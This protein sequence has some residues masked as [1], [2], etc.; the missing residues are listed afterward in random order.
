MKRLLLG[1]LPFFFYLPAQALIL[2][3]TY[4]SGREVCE[5]SS[6]QRTEEIPFWITV[7]VNY[8]DASQGTT[9]IYAWI[10][11][12]LDPEKETMIFINGGPGDTA[13]SLR[14]DLDHWNVIFFD[15]RGNSCSKPTTHELYL[16]RSF[17]SS[18]NT[19]RDI[20]EIRRFFE[21][22]Q[23]SVYGVSYGTIP[24]HLYGHFFP[25]NTK[26]VVLEGT[27]FQSDESLIEP[28]RRRQKLQTFF[29]S[30]PR[31]KQNRILS[32]S[33]RPEFP[34][35][36]FS[37]IGMMML[38]MDN[39]QE[40]YS[41]FLDTIIWDETAA[42]SMLG[43]FKSAEGED[44]EFGFGDVMMGMIG[45]QELNMN[46]SE[47]SF[48]S[49]FEN[50]KL[51]A[52]KTNTLKKLYCQSLGFTEAD[53]NK[54]FKASNYPT[55]VPVT[56]FQGSYDGATVSTQ[57][58]QHFQEAAK[59]FAQL[60]IST[61]G[62]QLPLH[63]KAASYAGNQKTVSL[64]KQ[65]LEKALSGAPIPPAQI[66]NLNTLPDTSWAQI[67]QPTPA[68]QT[69]AV[70]EAPIPPEQESVVPATPPQA[71][72]ATITEQPHEAPTQESPAS[73]ALASTPLE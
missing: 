32:L 10:K 29:E 44:T 68:T 33:K 25:Q 50:G 8:A 56:Y 60:L 12:P 35:N 26:G 52:D 51:V 7:P 43:A 61:T 57:S 53:Q 41:N 59:G 49:V 31:E 47:I 3:E 72:P 67:L 62:G 36:W 38:S 15:Q 16:S 27:I 9:Q 4:Y 5:R 46:N 37:T 39:A 18:E 40:T 11:K 48:Y 6:I 17:Y 45:C 70:P 65:L 42:T 1:L 55:V 22:R 58:V 14:L 63:S 66:E 64:H 2:S 30:L 24:A 20:N 19:A 73:S 28:E 71:S 13:H 23:V 34:A 54:T 21:L 69:P